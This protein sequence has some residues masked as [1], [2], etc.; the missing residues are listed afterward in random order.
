MGFGLIVTGYISFFCMRLIPI[1]IFGFLMMHIGF[2]KLSIY[3]SG[4]EKAKKTSLICLV[5][6]IIYGIFQILVLSRVIDSAL[7]NESF[8]FFEN[9]IYYSLL[10]LLHIYMYNGF[11]DI[12]KFC[13]LPRAAKKSTRCL[14]VATVYYS[15]TFLLYIL[16]LLPLKNNFFMQVLNSLFLA[17][18]L[19]MIVWLCMTASLIYTC[20][21]YIVTD[22]ILEKEKQ[23][24]DK[25]NQRFGKKK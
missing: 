1:D 19:L 18:N 6:S 9:I 2:K 14:S 16:K 21:R 17:T 15:F 20:Y 3:N 4:F 8:Y 25:F 5:Y 24:M 7:I 13:D 12:S 10:F 11:S 22:E 23:Q